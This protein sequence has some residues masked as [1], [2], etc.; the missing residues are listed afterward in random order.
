MIN[1][2]RSGGLFAKSFFV[3][4]CGVEGQKKDIA[5]IPNAKTIVKN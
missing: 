4:L 5:A 3:T 1:F 2:G